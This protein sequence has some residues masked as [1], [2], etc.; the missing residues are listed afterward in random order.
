MHIKKKFDAAITIDADNQIKPKSISKIIYYINKGFDVVI[1][2][3]NSFNRSSEKI[4]SFFTKYFF[5]ISDPL[6]G[7]KGY[8]MYIYKKMGFFDSYNSTGT[9]L[10]FFAKKKGYKIFETEISI[11]PRIGVSRY[12]NILSGNL[13]IYL[14]ILK[15]LYYLF[16]KK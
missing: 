7:L 5:N 8:K 6:C 2:K 11:Q 10:L 14:S 13:K 9:E 15:M 12:G 16:L 4:F 1:G 3:R